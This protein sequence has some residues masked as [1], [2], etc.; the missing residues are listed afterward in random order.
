MVLFLVFLMLFLALFALFLGGGLVGQGFL[1]QQ[2][3]ERLPLRAVIAALVVA[4]FITLWVRIDQGAPGKYDTFFNF[5]AYT[6]AEFDE[7]EAVRW[8]A[9]QGKLTLDAAGNPVETTVKFKR[10]GKNA[11][12]YQEGTKTPFDLRGTTETGGQFMIGAIRVKGPN[13]PKPVRY[14]ARFN[15]GPGAKTKTYPANKSD[16]RFT[17]EKG[18]RYVEEQQL[19]KLFVPSTG[20]VVIALLLNFLLVAVWLIAW[21]PAMRFSL[22]HSLMFTAV[23]AVITML[24]LMPVLFKP[25]RVP[26]A[27]QPPEKSVAA[28]AC[29]PPGLHH[30][31]V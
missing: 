9:S 8:A 12:F 18:S 6:T 24:A 29:A 19:G 20:T 22:G 7:F 27:P 4:G 26:K 23:L 1:Y 16:R 31:F 2:P 3:A 28:P 5:T 14:N 13:D 15:E 11:P 10:D 30:F 21:W 17:E 25:N